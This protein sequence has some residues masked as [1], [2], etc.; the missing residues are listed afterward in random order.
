MNDKIEFIRQRCIEANPEITKRHE[1][2]VFTKSFLQKERHRALESISGIVLSHK[3]PL[4]YVLKDGNRS[5]RWYNH[6]AIITTGYPVRLA[7][8]IHAV[9]QI[10]MKR[11]HAIC[12]QIC[13]AWE[14][15]KDDITEQS[16]ETVDFIHDLFRQWY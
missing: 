1:R 5:R 6:K 15:T 4:V 14:M 10:S 11:Q 2:F 8:I 7:D 12:M 3:G 9:D 13:E 16:P